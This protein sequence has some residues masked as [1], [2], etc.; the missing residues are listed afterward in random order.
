MLTSFAGKLLDPKFIADPANRI[1]KAGSQFSKVEPFW[2]DNGA[3]QAEHPA[4]NRRKVE[5]IKA[6]AGPADAIDVD[7][8]A[9]CSFATAAPGDS[10]GETSPAAKG[11]GKVEEEPPAEGLLR[12][13]QGF[14]WQDEKA[15]TAQRLDSAHG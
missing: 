3:Y 4:Y 12:A 8:G 14:N 15:P 6:G 9:L 13:D 5:N 2:K 11:K 7:Q 10:T 1:A